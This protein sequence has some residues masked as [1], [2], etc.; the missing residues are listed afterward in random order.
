[1]HSLSCAKGGYPSIQHNEIKD[2]TANLV[3]EVCS[4]ESVEPMLQPI[5][6]E[7]FLGASAN[8]QEG[9][10]LDI[11]ADGFW[12]GRVGREFVDICVFNPYA[13]SNQYQQQSAVYRKHE[14][15]KKR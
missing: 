14:N 12:G 5:T 11:A 15:E 4:N 9:A 13:A 7:T 8:V 2:L 1:M 6:G 10:R 3:T